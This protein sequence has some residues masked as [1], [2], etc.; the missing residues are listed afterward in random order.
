MCPAARP[1]A[2]SRGER[3]RCARSRRS[4]RARP[5]RAGS[6]ARA[7]CASR[8]PV[9]EGDRD[10]PLGELAVGVDPVARE[11]DRDRDALQLRWC[12]R[13]RVRLGQAAGRRAPVGVDA[14]E[15]R[16][17]ARHPR[18]VVRLA[19]LVLE[20]LELVVG[21]LLERAAQLGPGGRALQRMDALDDRG[22]V[23]GA[24]VVVAQ[25]DLLL[26]LGLGAVHL[27]R[28]RCRA[29]RRAGL[30]G[31]RPQAAEPGAAATSATRPARPNSRAREKNSFS[32][33][34]CGVAV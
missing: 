9:V 10:L 17:R 13:Q 14:A 25:R 7:P 30:A 2:R 31:V 5:R 33:S 11:V 24:G 21:Q 6:P 4:R 8:G 34:I 15:Q 12:G 23:I 19:D 22:G 3:R 27:L 1:G 18:R 16:R 28:A 29:G 26:Q 20:Q 32:M